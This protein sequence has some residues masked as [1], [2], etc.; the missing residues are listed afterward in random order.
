MK[1]AIPSRISGYINMETAIGTDPNS[2]TRP[3]TRLKSAK[4][5]GSAVEAS[6]PLVVR[7]SR[8]R[9]SHDLPATYCSA[10]SNKSIMTPHSRL[11]SVLLFMS[12]DHREGRGNGHRQQQAVQPAGPKD[13]GRRVDEAGVEV[14]AERVQQQVQQVPGG[15]AR[16][17]GL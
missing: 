13:S 11:P 14:R 15:R 9:A 17:G 5:S 8:S 6:V 3:A 1:P 12:H 4:Q 10:G 2:A 16:H 7:L